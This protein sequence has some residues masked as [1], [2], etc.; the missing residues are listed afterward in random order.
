MVYIS[1]PLHDLLIVFCKSFSFAL[2]ILLQH[3]FL[4]DK[5]VFAEEVD[6]EI[7]GM[8]ISY[9]VSKKPTPSGHLTYFC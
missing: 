7:N 9:F 3:I 6:Q 8:T 2:H 4:I 5:N 1:L